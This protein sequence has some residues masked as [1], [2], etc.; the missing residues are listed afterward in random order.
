MEVDL[1]LRLG[2]EIRLTKTNQFGSLF[3]MKFGSL[4]IKD[5]E[6]L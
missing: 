3:S 4:R 2:V 6:V 5:R 1:Q